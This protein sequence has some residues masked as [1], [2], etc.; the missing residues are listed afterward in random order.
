MFLSRE[1]DVERAR[2][3]LGGYTD[4]AST[5]EHLEKHSGLQLLAS[6][7]DS[8]VTAPLK[9]LVIAAGHPISYLRKMLLR[10]CLVGVTGVLF[11]AAIAG[12]APILLAVGY[13][14]IELFILKNAVHKRAESFEKDYTALLLSLAS[15]VRTG[16]DP[17]VALTRSS[18]LFGEDSEVGH[19]V[20][21]L[22]DRIERGERE[23]K[24][25]GMF[26]ATID[27]PDVR[28]F[29]AAF[30]LSRREGSSLAEC[31]QR[32]AKV[33]RQ[34]Q[35]FRRRMRAAVAMQKLSAVGIAVCTVVIGII[36]VGANP[37]AMITAWNHPIGS[38]A[39]MAGVSLV[40][41]GLVWML[42]MTRA[43]I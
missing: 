25:V 7:G 1:D 29:R 33:T 17:L 35:S 20:K 42:R 26:G 10:L 2:Q 18:E 39:I 40:L 34:R 3:L 12:P 41:L 11:S 6:F 13:L 36:Q 30:I 24:A 16:L 14:F 9:R 31:L 22:A 15:G 32:L 19:E 43:R 23:E 37:T 27:H 28:L 4:T 5:P 8:F 21:L 38:K